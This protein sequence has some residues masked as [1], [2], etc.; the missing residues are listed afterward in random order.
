MIDFIL[1]NKVILSI[2]TEGL[3]TS[4]IRETIEL[5]AYENNVKTEQI[6][7]KVREI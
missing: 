1:N 6:S 4:E 2:S 3:F 7:I 5:L